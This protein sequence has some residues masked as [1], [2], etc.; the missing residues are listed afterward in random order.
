MRRRIITKAALL[1]G[2]L[3]VATEISHGNYKITLIEF[4]E[5][6]KL[7]STNCNFKSRTQFEKWKS[8]RI[9]FINNTVMIYY[10]H[11]NL[12]MLSN[13]IDIKSAISLASS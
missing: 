2:R 9:L 6:T 13:Y 11:S 4:K 8:F 3:V 5:I 1:P 10:L 12:T 7:C